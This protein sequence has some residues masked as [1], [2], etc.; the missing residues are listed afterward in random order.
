MNVY[1][2]RSDDVYLQQSFRWIEEDF[3]LVSI[4]LAT[5][6]VTDLDDQSDM[7]IFESLLTTFEAIFIVWGSWAI[8]KNWLELKTKPQ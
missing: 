6:C 5:E 8:C 3:V 7:I 1:L 2:E 4:I